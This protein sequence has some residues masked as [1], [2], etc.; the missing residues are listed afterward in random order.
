LSLKLGSRIWHPAEHDLLHFG[1]CDPEETRM[2]PPLL[3]QGTLGRRTSLIAGAAVLGVLYAGSPLVTPLYP[4]YEE[5]FG[6]SE[7]MVTLIY[8]AY[9]I[10]NLGALFAFGKVSDRA[11]RRFVSLAVLA[12][13]IAS[14]LLFL[15]ATDSAWLFVARAVSGLAIGV[16]A[17]TATAWIAELHPSPDKAPASRLAAAVNL[18]GLAAGALAAGLLAQ[19]AP[20]PLRTV[21]V[22]YLVVLAA[23]AALTAPARETVERRARSMKELSFEPRIGIPPELRIAFIAPA[24]TAFATFALLGFYAALL[25]NLLA[26][27]MH[28]HSPA[29]SGAI[30]AE[31]FIASAIT[32]TA[33]PM[34]TARAAMF[35][36]LWLLPPSLAVLLWAQATGSVAWLIAATAL[37]G[38][39]SA[40]GFR[41]SLQEANRM[42]PARQ[43]AE[44]LSAYL[45]CC[46]TG[47]SLP[48]VGVALL[49][50]SV[51]HL[52]ADVVFAAV[53]V[54]LAFVALAVGTRYVQR[55]G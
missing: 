14:T 19:Y 51:G 2:H 27:S 23:T 49:S 31:L 24:V 50:R 25:P 38:I 52:W 10:G 46:Y 54:V 4:L 42:A 22:V 37:S 55:S 36:G 20:W 34:L 28:R 17:A 30:V 39:A 7:L 35:A 32:V 47:N 29:L 15:F 44:L 8:A 26:N 21:F 5:Q 18:I 48:A 6:L 41:G 33:T 1:R 16:G 12:V 43:R 13:A 11:G 9:V 3:R 45:L 40:L 53:S